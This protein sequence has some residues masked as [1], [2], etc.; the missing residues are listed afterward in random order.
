MTG[1]LKPSGTGTQLN[2]LALRV[3]WWPSGEVSG[4]AMP[5]PGFN[6]NWRTEISVGDVAQPKQ[7]NRLAL[8]SL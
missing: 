2:K 3:P 4:L 8:R 5:W 1:S 6:P 7:T